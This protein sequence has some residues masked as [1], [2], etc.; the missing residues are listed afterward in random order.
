MLLNAA[1]LVEAT[2]LTVEVV[3]VLEVVLVVVVLVAVVAVLEGADVA[4]VDA[5]CAVEVARST[6]AT[7][8]GSQGRTG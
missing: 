1:V 2:L 7:V 3:L 8:K 4:A 5:C 6:S